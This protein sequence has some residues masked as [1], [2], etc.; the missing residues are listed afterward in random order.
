MDI[1]RY[2]ADRIKY[3]RTKCNLTQEEV[4]EALNLTPQTVS[5]YENGERKTNQDILFQL[6]QLFHV[7]MND[8]FPTI[9]NASFKEPEPRT[10]KIPVLG[11][12]KAGVPIEAQEEIIDY[13]DIPM[14]WTKGSK[15]F[16]ALQISGDSM[17]PKYN[18]KDI[19][20]FE[21]TND[22]TR[23][24]NKDCAVMV[25]CTECTF[26]KVFVNNDGITLQPYNIN[27]QALAFDK[28]QVSKLPVSIIGIA[29]EKRVK[30]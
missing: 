17:S 1:S 8:F 13:I 4:A 29:V 12:I 20:I 21:Q 15:E 18:D 26:K 10:I 6:C 27:Y 5:R 2:V 23:A 25:N 11:Y 16:Y 28:N 22:Y 9:D 24:N 3:F 19:V 30:I 7:S 14:I